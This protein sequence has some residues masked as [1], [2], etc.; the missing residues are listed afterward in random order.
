MYWKGKKNLAGYS[1]YLRRLQLKNGAMTE[2][3][4]HKLNRLE[5]F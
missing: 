4:S 3:K 1:P 5:L 2:Y